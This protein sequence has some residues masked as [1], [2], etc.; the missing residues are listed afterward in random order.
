MCGIEVEQ[1]CRSMARRRCDAGEMSGGA[2]V[3]P[4]ETELLYSLCRVSE[5]VHAPAIYFLQ[6][7]CL[8]PSFSAL[9]S[10]PSSC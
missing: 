3:F 10:S 1:Q 5:W 8:F 9:A 4:V 6:R 2:S 7:S